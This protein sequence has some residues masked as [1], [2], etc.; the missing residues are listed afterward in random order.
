M[1]AVEPADMDLWA[2]W[3]LIRCP[4]LVLRGARS[5]LLLPETAEEM[6]R[7]G[8]TCTVHEVPDVGHAP[9]FTTR[10]LNR[11]VADFLAG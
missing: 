6:T 2:L 10:E 7:R 3:D 11:V 5:D 1:K 4:V 9:M 8:P